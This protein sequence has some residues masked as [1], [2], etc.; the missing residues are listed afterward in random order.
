[1]FRRRGRHAAAKFQGRYR[2]MEPPPVTQPLPAITFAEPEPL[3]TPAV[4]IAAANAPRYDGQAVCVTIG[5]RHFVAV[6]TADDPAEW[7]AALAALPRMDGNVTRIDQGAMPEGLLAASGSGPSRSIVVDARLA[8]AAKAAA[9]RK[10]MQAARNQGLRTVVLAPLLALRHAGRVF[11]HGWAAAGSVA[12]VATAGVTVAAVS[13]PISH[14]IDPAAPPPAPAAH[15]P[16]GRRQDRLPPGR[17][18]SPSHIPGPGHPAVK[19]FITPMGSGKTSPYPVITPDP[20]V[21]PPPSPTPDPTTQ[22]PP[23]PSPTPSVCVSVLVT[24]ICAD[25][26]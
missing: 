1:M 17:R 2:A 6:V 23:S 22:A 12:V 10:V 14:I 16:R 15:H 18:V 20:V 11:T 3:E 21:S 5:D 26:T 19:H 4:L 8:C 24:G 7:T 13:P 25:V 9:V